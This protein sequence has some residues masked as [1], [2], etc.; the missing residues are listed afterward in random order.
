SLLHAVTRNHH[1]G[2][3][4]TSFSAMPGHFLSHPALNLHAGR[5]D[6]WW[7]SSKVLSVPGLSRNIAASSEFASTFAPPTKALTCSSHECIRT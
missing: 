5:H 2:I 1:H 6:E 4:T 3:A 7:T